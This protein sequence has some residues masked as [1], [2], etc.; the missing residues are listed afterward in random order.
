MRSALRGLVGV[1]ALL[2]TLIISAAAS[3]KSSYYPFTYAN[4]NGPK[5]VIPSYPKRVAIYDGGGL[6]LYASLGIKPVVFQNDVYPDYTPGESKT[7]VPYWVNGGELSGVPT[8][9]GGSAGPN[10]EE[11]AS[12]HPDLIIGMQQY[13]ADFGAIAPNVGGIDHALCNQ[14]LEPGA[15][16]FYGQNVWSSIATVF[17][18]TTRM[19]EIIAR[20][21]DR[22]NALAGFARGIS[23]DLPEFPAGQNFYLTTSDESLGGIFDLIGA[24]IETISGA[25]YFA[26]NEFQLVSYELLSKMT[27]TKVIAEPSPPSMTVAEIKALP[28]YNSIPAVKTHQFYF[29]NEATF[30][31]I[32]TADAITQLGKQVYGVGG[33]EAPLTKPGAKT[34]NPY[35]AADVDIGPTDKR[36]CWAIA[37]TGI[38]ERPNKVA[39]QSAAGKQVLALGNGYQPTG[40]ANITK[41]DGERLLALRQHYTVTVEKTPASMTG[42]AKLLLQGTLGSQSPAFFGNGKDMQYNLGP[43]AGAGNTGITCR[44][45]QIKCQD[46]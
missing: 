16:Q 10:Y 5:V 41:A 43:T 14:N 4:C 35:D 34:S 7:G 45:T 46:A 39:I 40:C 37:T 2:T 42:T 8:L 1:A 23:V 9:I 38:S 6:D 11:I 25:S 32:S 20:L 31:P 33:L 19:N 44:P 26:G 36:I 18:K 13:A 12:Y 17:D 24:K 15:K 27:A 3:A 30:G 29:A 22:T 28:L 21:H